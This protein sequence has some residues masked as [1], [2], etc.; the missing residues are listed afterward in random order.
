[1]SGSADKQ[2]D[3]NGS[4]MRHRFVALACASV[5]AGMVGLSYAAVPL[6]RL[7][8]QVT[9]FA[10]TPQVAIAPSTT[11]V[12]QKLTMRFDANVSRDL[13]GWKF[14]PQ[15]RTIDVRYGENKIAIYLATNTTDKSLT[16]TASFNVTPEIAGVY[17]NKIECFCFT[18]QTLKPGE[19]VEMPVSF[20]VDPEMLK[21]KDAAHLSQLTLSYTFFPSSPSAAEE[22]EKAEAEKRAEV[23]VPTP[24]QDDGNGT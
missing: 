2:P 5:V 17:F 11:L 16:G 22:P 21:D 7:Y 8:C 4:A 15:K 18:E 6:Y 23:K 20:Y 19:S 9:G 24:V 10:G 14:R 13:A 12:D 3:P 1:M